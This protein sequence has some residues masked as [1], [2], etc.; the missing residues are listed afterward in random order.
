MCSE[1]ASVF[2]PSHSHFSVAVLSLRLTDAFNASRDKVFYLSSLLP[3]CES[4]LAAVSPS[5]INSDSL[6]ALI[7]GMRQLEGLSRAFAKSGFLGIILRKVAIDWMA[8]L[9]SHRKAFFSFFTFTRF[10]TPSL[11]PA[12]L[13]S[14]N[15]PP[16][17]EAT[18]SGSRS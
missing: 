9:S 8:F 14:P 3:H 10:P 15:Y 16:M 5:S 2:P 17:M 6:P 7:A 12:R 1:Y 13:L 18:L 4:I 11:S